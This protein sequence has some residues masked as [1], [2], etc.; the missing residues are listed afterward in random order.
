MSNTLDKLH[1]DHRNQAKLLQMVERQAE[2][3][4]RGEELDLP[5][6]QLAL[7]YFQNYPD[8][9]HHPKE[10]AL[11]E[12]LVARDESVAQQITNIRQDHL[13]LAAET[14]A[15]ADE[16][17]RPYLTPLDLAGRLQRFVDHYRSHMTIEEAELFP[18]A[19]TLLD[20]E[21]WAHVEAEIAP[22]VDPLFD[23]AASSQYQRLFTALV[24]GGS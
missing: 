15:I 12:R 1:I 16:L 11:Y 14:D 19:R 18:R 10:D 23:G 7:Q 17:S 24:R 20:A 21:D 3:V 2:G 4:R 8:L 13:R 22:A 5:L 9:L 6:L